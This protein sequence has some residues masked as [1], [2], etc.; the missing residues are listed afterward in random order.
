MYTLIIFLY[1]KISQWMKWH[2]NYLPGLI[3][4]SPAL[5]TTFSAYKFPNKVAVKIP[6]NLLKIC[7]F[8]STFYQWADSSRALNIFV[9]SFNPFPVITTTVIPDP[10]FFNE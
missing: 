4:L 9:I 2:Q 5:A 1:F 8:A 10:I 6:N 7:F 3:I